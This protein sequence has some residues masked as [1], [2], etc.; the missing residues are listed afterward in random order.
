ME[1]KPE[2]LSLALSDLGA[3]MQRIL[4]YLTDLGEGHT[5]TQ[6]LYWKVGDVR[7]EVAETP[8]LAVGSLSDDWRELLALARDADRPVTAV[9]L[10]RLAALLGY[11]SAEIS[12]D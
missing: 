10:D 5:L 2:N 11:L 7:Y 12:R 6:D 9:D 4:G 8:T 3:C 1:N